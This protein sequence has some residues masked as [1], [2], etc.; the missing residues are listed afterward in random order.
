M[1]KTHTNNRRHY[2]L[3]E[4]MSWHINSKCLYTY[5]QQFWQ[6]ALVIHITTFVIK[7]LNKSCIFCRYRNEEQ[8]LPQTVEKCALKY[9]CIQTDSNTIQSKMALT[10]RQGNDLQATQ[11]QYSVFVGSEH[12]ERSQPSLATS[13]QYFVLDHDAV[14]TELPVTMPC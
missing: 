10:K 12:G 11:P 4:Q 5:Q 6:H 13:S 8:K 14:A 2:K 7:K 1:L 9:S 3:Q